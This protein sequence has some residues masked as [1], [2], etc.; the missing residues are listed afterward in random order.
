MRHGLERLGDRQDA[1][2][3]RDG[4]TDQAVRIAQAV[5]SASIRESSW[6]SIECAGAGDHLRAR[7]NNVGVELGA[8]APEQLENGVGRRTPLAMRLVVGDRFNGIDHRQNA[9][10]ERNGRA[11]ETIGVAPPILALA[12]RAQ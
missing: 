5:F 6:I 2:A 11:R 10:A 12:Q 1:A 4:G 9:A 8:G 3:K 7:V